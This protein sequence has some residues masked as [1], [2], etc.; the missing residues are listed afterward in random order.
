MYAILAGA[1]IS[2]DR[3]ADAEGAKCLG[4]TE[5]VRPAYL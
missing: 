2:L 3:L 1:Y 5:G 4:E